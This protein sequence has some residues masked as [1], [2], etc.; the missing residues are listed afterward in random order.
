MDFYNYYRHRP[1]QHSS[2]ILIKSTRTLTKLVTV[3]EIKLSY[4]IH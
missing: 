4:I 3:I 1:Q 2:E